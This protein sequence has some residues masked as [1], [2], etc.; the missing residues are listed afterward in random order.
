M[1]PA[2]YQ[3][4]AV[5]IPSFTSMQRAN[6]RPSMLPKLI[7]AQTP[8]ATTIGEM[9][10]SPYSALSMHSR[11]SSGTSDNYSPLT[12]T[13]SFHE[14]TRHPSSSSSSLATTPPKYEPSI[15]SLNNRISRT[16]L[17]DLVEDPHERED[18]FDLCDDVFDVNC[19]CGL[20]QTH[21]NSDPYYLSEAEMD[22]RL[23]QSASALERPSL[24]YSLA[25]GPSEFSS[26][27]EAPLKLPKIRSR[28]NSG[29]SPV[30]GLASRVGSRLSSFSKRRDRTPTSPPTTAVHRL[31]TKSAP[32][33]RVPSRAPSFRMPS[34]AKPVLTP[35]DVEA[36]PTP[37]P[38]PTNLTVEP[39]NP[40]D[41]HIPREDEPFDR[42]AL[43]ST[44]LLPIPIQDPEQIEEDVIQS[45]LQSP[46]VVDNTQLARLSMIGP[47]LSSPVLPE[48]ALV[49]PAL[50]AHASTSSLGNMHSNQVMSS[51]DISSMHIVSPQ[52]KWA[53]KLGHANFSVFPEPYLPELYN[54]HACR[55]LFEDWESARRQFMH[56][57]ARTSEHYGPTSQVYKYTEK[58]WAEID[59]QWKRNH[60]LV[61][62]KTAANGET[63]VFQPLAE[64]APLTDLPALDDPLKFPKLD[65]SDIVGPMVKYAKIKQKSSSK[66]SA[67]LKFFNNVRTPGN[68]LGRTPTGLGL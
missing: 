16:T 2:R 20:E 32:V 22:P 5:Q 24:D 25:D 27:N 26:D 45:P 61:V 9:A 42:K 36:E 47:S 7:V 4:V 12:Q 46:T 15:E 21:S 62:A 8:T 17:H 14:H 65:G 35:V 44:P 34:A 51:P 60:E 52:D 38:T 50:S 3:D 19:Q 37:T 41:I 48:M 66:K 63:P 57:A 43:A 54:I 10:D 13:F 58:K 30:T 64:P 28:Q 31:G 67:F 56:Q 29:D 59:A 23:C 49:S 11:N 6:M 39:S 40:L 53:S 1:G 68:T 33:S 55:K 18:A